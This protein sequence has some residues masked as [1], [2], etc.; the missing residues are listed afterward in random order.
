MFSLKFCSFSFSE[1]LGV[2][3]A[4]KVNRM[5][6]PVFELFYS[7]MFSLLYQPKNLNWIKFRKKREETL[8]NGN[9]DIFCH[10]SLNET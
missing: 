6:F 2:Q 1:I 4:F 8:S 5:P 9:S 10:Q 7:A 3:R